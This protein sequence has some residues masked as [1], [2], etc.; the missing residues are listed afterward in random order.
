MAKYPEK[1][2]SSSIIKH[3]AESTNTTSK[4]VKEIL[5][6]FFDCIE[7]GTLKGHRVPIAHIGKVYAHI[8][9]ARKS[10]EGIN[11]LTGEKIKIAAKPATKVPKFNFTKAFKETILKAKVQKQ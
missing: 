9:P 5:D 2:T 8:K 10:R 1:F 7:Q 4:D 3:V 11:P 6:I